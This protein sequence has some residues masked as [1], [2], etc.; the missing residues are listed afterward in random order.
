MRQGAREASTRK[1]RGSQPRAAVVLEPRATPCAP[2]PPLR[3]GSPAYAPRHPEESVLYAVVR[4]S[5]KLNPR[6]G[7]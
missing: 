4:G 1:A 5:D 2:C 6:S 7:L 3:S